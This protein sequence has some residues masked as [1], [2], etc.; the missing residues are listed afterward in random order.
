M[1]RIRVPVILTCLLG[2]CFCTGSNEVKT[3]VSGMYKFTHK[4]GAVELWKIGKDS[5]FEESFYKGEQEYLSGKAML[6]YIGEWSLKSNDARPVLSFSECYTMI[7]YG[8]WRTLEKPERV[9]GVTAGWVK[10]RGGSE[11]VDYLDFF[12]ATGYLVPK[13][14]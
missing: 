12:E 4:N 1:N 14:K 7:D 6:I 3:Q 9:T 13:I 8:N 10:G 2:L 5:K 11:S